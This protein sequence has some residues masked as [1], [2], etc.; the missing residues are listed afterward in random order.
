M[1]LMK[2]P[3]IYGDIIVEKYEKRPENMDHVTFIDFLAHWEKSS[4][5]DYYVRKQPKIVRWIDYD[6]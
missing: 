5:H 6:I 2:N 3:V 1:K 4:K